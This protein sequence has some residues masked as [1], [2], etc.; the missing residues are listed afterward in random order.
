MSA[1]RLRVQG[2]RTAALAKIITAAR[3]HRRG[4]P[5]VSG[6][7]GPHDRQRVSRPS[8]P[9]SSTA[10][11][12]HPDPPARARK[13]DAAE[14]P[15]GARGLQFEP[16]EKAPA[17]SPWPIGRAALRRP[18]RDVRKE[19]PE[20][21]EGGDP[22]RAGRPGGGKAERTSGAKPVPKGPC[23]RSVQRGAY[24]RPRGSRC[25]ATACGLPRRAPP[26]SSVGDFARARRMDCVAQ[27][28]MCGRYRWPF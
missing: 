11:R 10:G 24:R 22:N 7:F 12:L 27:K 8:R 19:K 2:Q 26:P 16:K 17:R 6:G 4:A 3:R 9:A 25:C 28:I 20:G 23:G 18:R 5:D 15:S 13:G 1:S 21:S 14:A